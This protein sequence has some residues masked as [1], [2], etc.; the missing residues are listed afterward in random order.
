MGY[1]FSDA[2]AE[3]TNQFAVDIGITKYFKKGL[4]VWF[5][6]A[7]DSEFELYVEDGENLEMKYFTFPVGDVKF[8]PTAAE[9][10]MEDIFDDAKLDEYKHFLSEEGSK[11]YEQ[12]KQQQ[13]NLSDT[14]SNANVTKED[15]MEV[16]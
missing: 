3:T 14:D 7:V 4:N 12:F 15:D 13:A 16:N 2:V 10:I 1:Y 6:V 9:W 5:R 11:L 8:T